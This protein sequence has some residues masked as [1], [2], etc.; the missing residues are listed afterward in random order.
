M[1]PGGRGAAGGAGRG[2]SDIAEWESG[3]RWTAS[4]AMGTTVHVCLVGAGPVVGVA[5]PAHDVVAEIDAALS[6][7]LPASEVSRI[8]AS[9]GRW[10]PVGRHLA[11]VA[12][13]AERYRALTAG[14]FDAIVADTPVEGPRLRFRTG[15][16]GVREAFLAPGCRIDLGGIAKGYAAD[17][18]RDRCEADAHGVMVSVGTSSISFTGTP[19]VRE[20]WRIAI[21]SP[22]EDVPET[23]GYIEVSRGSFS[24]SGVRG[25]RRGGERI[26]P[27]HLL[28][29]RTGGRVRTDVCAV[30]VLSDDGM[31]SE[32]LSTACMVL[33]T[34]PGLEL[35][36][37]EQVEAL[38]LTVSGD[39]VATPGMGRRVS[40]RRGIRRRLQ[41]VLDR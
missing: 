10:L 40:L 26:V 23:L 8:N 12:E 16:S 2:A 17:A 20:A 35:C 19:P 5:P 14:A 32:A 29:P 34:G 11:A 39:L 24:M 27:Q 38:F 33:G 4:T 9:P 30:G 41:D 3:G 15:A 18:A 28:D 13:A 7:F 31:R 21:G 25:Q 6:R 37:D 1:T 36:A 22:W